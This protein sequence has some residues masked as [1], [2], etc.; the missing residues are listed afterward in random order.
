MTTIDYG[1][2]ELLLRRSQTSQRTL[3]S[4]EARIQTYNRLVAEERQ[5][6]LAMDEDTLRDLRSA[7]L[8]NVVLAAHVV[9]H[10]FRFLSSDNVI[11]VFEAADYAIA[12]VRGL[13]RVGLVEER[14]V[15]S[16][17]RIAAAAA[18]TAVRC[19][20]VT[21]DIV[22]AYEEYDMSLG[23]DPDPRF[24]AK[25]DIYIWGRV[26]CREHLKAKLTAVRSGMH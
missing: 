12:G 7:A 20:R 2:A 6:L 24:A 4:V 14:A 16:M 8:H 15:R 13:H 18:A 22:E 21:D 11:R 1:A 5:A 9:R 25:N 26:L 17:A 10:G 3:P 19:G 23:P